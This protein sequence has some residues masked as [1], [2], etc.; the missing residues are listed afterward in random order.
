MVRTDVRLAFRR[1]RSRP[2]ATTVLIGIIAVGIGAAAA[3]FSVVDQTLLRPAPF[4]FHDRLVMAL[5]TNRKTGGGGSSLTPAKIAGW[6]HQPS[7]F[8]RF[9]GVAPAQ[10]DITRDG[11]PERIMGIYVTPGLFSMLGVSPT[12]GRAFGT[13][14]GQPGSARVAIVSDALWHSRL[15]GD[16]DALGRTLTLN[17]DAYTVV[18]VLP[19]RLQLMGEDV[20]VWL[21]YD[22]DSHLSDA[23]MRSFYGFGRLARGVTMETAQRTADAVADQL[24]RET[25]LPRSWDLAIDP[26][27]IAWVDPTSK[28]ALYVLLGAVGFLLLI[29]C[30][31]V[32]SLLL[33]QAP[34]RIRE[35]AIA[36]AIGS[37]RA[38]LVRAVLVET[39][40]L[41]SAGGAAGIL[42]GRWA[43]DAI[44]AIAP[45]TLSWQNATSIE[46]DGRIVAV[47]F[48][49][50]LV[51]GIA[52]GLLPAWRGSRQAIESGLRTSSR[53]TATPFGRASSVLIAV[54]VAFSL[55]L[56]TGA[57][58]MARTLLNLNAI[59]PGFEPDGVISMHVDLPSDRY[60]TQQ[61]RA[62]FF[63]DAR[64]RLA[65]VP[66]VLDSA[67]AGGL[68]PDQ[69]GFRGGALQAEGRE[70]EPTH[71]IFPINTISPTYFRTLRIPI[72]AGR[73]FAELEQPDNVIVSQG[74]ADHLW[75]SA[76]AIGRRFRVGDGP[77]KTVVGVVGT[78][79]SRA[80]RETR[81]SLQVYWPRNV[82]GPTAQP[83]PPSPRRTYAYRVL[84][85][86]A[87]NPLAALPSIQQAIWSVD[88]DQPIERVELATDVYGEAFGRQRF[89]LV[90]M[91]AFAAI[92]LALTMAGL[93]GVL[94][95]IVARRTREIGIR[96][97][98]GAA[99]SNVRRLV[100]RQGVVMIA[101]GAIAGVAVALGLTRTLQTLL[102]EVR[103]NDPLTLTIATFGLCAAGVAACW[104]PVRT[105]LR[106]APA[107]ALRTE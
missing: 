16:T 65:R 88:R 19:R 34:Q 51:I 17:G 66:G 22:V 79:E 70:P 103:P 53:S 106:I 57:A 97:A 31:N 87:A 33:A 91:V 95:Q 35:M 52:I 49:V 1:L 20:Q 78:V 48:A 85:V 58:L 50:T 107:E 63:E 80:A 56:L 38:R 8:E 96:V 27:Q 77:W 83:A 29:M 6:Q 81:T 75:P 55:V 90:L 24:Q 86:R 84:I 44:L 4:L 32:A 12:F 62:A 94:S 69:G 93:V 100:L 45:K 7:V 14:D 23:N 5:D 104:F 60:P 74:F 73:T 25:P 2:A 47:A 41:A 43:L 36:S 68:P 76:S 15:G 28:Q 59:A 67:V 37:T 21:P 3:V 9:E 13:Q 105:A 101:I 92:A 102:F 54:E 46:L 11:P 71:T 98:L 64:G 26:L 72:V 61:A 39:V 89:V 40:L 30:A 42:L 99:P 10:F 82:A 18:G